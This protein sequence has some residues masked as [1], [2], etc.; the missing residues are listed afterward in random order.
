MSRARY[1]ASRLSTALDDALGLVYGP[2]SGDLATGVKLH[3]FGWKVS[4]LHHVCAMGTGVSFGSSLLS[5][6]CY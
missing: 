6:C 5:A 2:L 1:C 4:A 3:K